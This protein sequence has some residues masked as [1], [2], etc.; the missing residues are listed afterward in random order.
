MKLLRLLPLV[1]ITTG[2]TSL[3]ITEQKTM[4]LELSALSKTDAPGLEVASLP[5]QLRNVYIWTK[6]NGEKVVCSE[7][8]PDVAASTTFKATAEAVNNLTAVVSQALEYQIERDRSLSRNSTAEDGSAASGSS[9]ATGSNDFSTNNSVNN[10]LSQTLK[11]GMETTS[12]MV[13]LGGRNDLVLLSREMLFSNCMLAANGFTGK[14]TDAELP[15]SEAQANIKQIITVISEMVTADRL[16]A[17]AKANEAKA[18]EN[19]AAAAK[20]KAEESLKKTQASTN[21]ALLATYTASLDKQLAACKTAAGTDKV[22]LSTCQTQYNEDLK[23]LQEGF[24]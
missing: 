3:G 7:P 20:A 18:A 16:K 17:E 22:K 19:T 9:G 21:S 10:T 14:P 11:L 2:C 13:N 1:L 23:A 6:S 15:T 12:T 8:V 4:K 24:K 5:A